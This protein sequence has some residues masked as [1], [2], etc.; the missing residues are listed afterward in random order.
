HRVLLSFPTRRSSDL[1][2]LSAAA[3]LSRA[4]GT[5]FTSLILSA[6]C[7]EMSSLG[8]CGFLGPS[9]CS[10]LYFTYNSLIVAR[11]PSSRK[12]VCVN[13]S[14]EHTSELQSPDHL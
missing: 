12:R 10:G 14:E 3:R 13:R 6:P 1:L 9:A 5:R 2:T 4:S 8:S 11:S 7:G